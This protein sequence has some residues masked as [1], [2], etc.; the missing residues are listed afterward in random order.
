MRVARTDNDTWEITESV[1]ATALGVASHRAAETESDNPLISDPFARVFLDAV[2]DGVWNWHSAAQLPP[3]LIEAEPELPL[4]MQAMVDYMAS[5]TK[6]FD[7]FFLDA[8][9]AGIR[10]AVILAAGLDSRSWRLPWPDG[11]TVYEL[12][13][14]RVLDFKASTLAKHGAQ[15]ACNR[16]AVPVDLRQDW[17]KAL[18]QAGFDASA[19]SVW[20][21]EGLTPYLPAAAQELLLERVHDLTVTGSRVAVEAL[22]PTFLDP[23]IRAKRRARMDRV[24]ELMAKVDPQREIPTMDELWYFEEREAVGDWF[25]RHGWDVEVTPSDELMAGYGRRPPEEVKDQVPG[26]LFVAARR[27]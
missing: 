2:G 27:T 18:Q 8:T 21:A 3:E 17:P 14:P 10:Q 23:E 20:S 15:P 9:R 24:R 11:V 4:Q 13:Q 26:N 16:V 6:F 5:R 12:D 19:P 22:G 7:T 25:G 1:G